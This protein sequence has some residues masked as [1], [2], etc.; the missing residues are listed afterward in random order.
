MCIDTLN[1]AATGCDE[2]SN[3]DMSVITSRAGMIADAING[4][5]LFVH[6][7]GKDNTKGLRGHSSLNAALDIAIEVQPENVKNPRMFKVTKSKDAAINVSQAFRLKIIE[8]GLDDDGDLITSCVVEPDL[9]ALFTHEPVGKNQIAA[10]ELLKPKLPIAL[11]EAEK[12]VEEV[13]TCTR[14]KLRAKESISSLVF[15]GFFKLVDGVLTTP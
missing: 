2:N 13:L 3:I 10:F 1:Q 4:L 8:L 14:A 7:T 6:H 11:N 15:G 12:R 9:S 5:V